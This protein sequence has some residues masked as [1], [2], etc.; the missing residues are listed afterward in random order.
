[1]H[2]AGTGQ[3]LFSHAS[4]NACLRLITA[5]SALHPQSTI[6]NLLSTIYYP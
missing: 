3:V 6:H 1:V 5:H 2:D 4:R